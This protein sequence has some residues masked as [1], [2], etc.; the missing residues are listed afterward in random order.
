MI[1]EGLTKAEI[2]RQLNI[3]KST[4]KTALK[5]TDKSGRWRNRYSKHRFPD[6]L[7]VRESIVCAREKTFEVQ[8]TRI[9]K[10]SLRRGI[11]ISIRNISDEEIRV[12]R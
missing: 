8:N 2:T 9:Y 11:K 10:A 6:S 4:V 5:Q 12:T 7:D 1:N 3:S